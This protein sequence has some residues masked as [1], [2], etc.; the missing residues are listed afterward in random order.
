MLRSIARFVPSAVGTVR[1]EGRLAKAETQLHWQERRA[2]MKTKNFAGRLWRRC[3]SQFVLIA[4]AAV[5]LS[6]TTVVAGIAQSHPP[7][8]PDLIQ[9]PADFGS[10]G[11]AAGDGPTFYVGSFT[12]PY[13]GQILVGDLRTGSLAVLVPTGRPVA[14]VKF[15][16]RTK[17]LYAA[18]GITGGGVVYDARSGAEIAFYQFVA[19]GTTIINDVTVTHEAAYFTDSFRP[20]LGRVALGPNGEP[21]QGDLV[22]LPANFGNPGS[23]TFGLPPRANGIT[24]TP[25]GKHLIVVHMSE[26]QLYLI[27]ATTFTTIP[28]VVSGGDSAG[29]AAACGGDGLLLDGQTLYVVQAPLN[30]VA[31]IEM[32]ADYL[33]GVVTRYITEPFASNPAT[34]FPTT[35]AAFGHSL[36]AVTYGDTPPTPDF[37]VRLPK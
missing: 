26:G 34:Q 32:S 22:P 18:G 8:F 33:S 17:F 14:G 27:D 9:L 3:G 15:D 11:I 13:L 21:G 24:A 6:L 12:P 31:V 19:P 16:S 10:E 7:V 23:C 28:I 25:N 35:I 1:F 30:R 29:G 37:V 2:C 4:P 20:F 5:V 36:Y